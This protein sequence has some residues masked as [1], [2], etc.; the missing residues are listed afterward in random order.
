M[1][2]PSAE[3]KPTINHVAIHKL[4]YRHTTIMKNNTVIFNARQS[5]YVNVTLTSVPATVVAVEN[6]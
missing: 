2:P 4:I 6:Q 1:F 3:F 5:M